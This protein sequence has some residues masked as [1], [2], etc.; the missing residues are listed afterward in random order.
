MKVLQIGMSYNP[1][2]VESFVMNYYRQLVQKGV[3]FD[4]ISMFPKLA[5]EEEIKKL[6]GQVFHISNVKSEPIRYTTELRAIIRTGKYDVVHVNMLSAA[7]ILPLKVASKCGVKNVIAHSHNSSS[8][9]VVRN[10]MHVLNKRSIMRYA[11]KYFACSNIAGRWLFP[12]RIWDNSECCII[13]NALD[14]EKFRYNRGVRDEVRKELNLEKNFIV[15][16]VG[17]FEEQKNH[18]FLIKIFENV[19]MSKPNAVL[20]LVGEGELEPKIREMVRQAGLEK[21]VKFLGVRDD[22]DR[23]WQAMDVF[24]LPSLFEGLPIVAVEAQAAGVPSILSDTITNDVKISQDL[25]FVSLK[26]SPD[27]WASIVDKMNRN[28]VDHSKIYNSFVKCGY[29][30]K[31]AAEKMLQYYNE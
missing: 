25:M 26:K 30:I 7:N 2:G 15:G 10:I 19:V 3:Q 12:K 20:L 28:N 22:V 18:I 11:T 14:L 9:G 23:I 4:F 31:S 21:N 27:Y 1:G 16:H 8:P 13:K 29:E 5:Y 17:R 6:G 24:L